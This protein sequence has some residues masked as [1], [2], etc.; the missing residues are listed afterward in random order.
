MVKEEE[1]ISIK[2]IYT[3]AQEKGF[4]VCETYQSIS[5]CKGFMIPNIK[6]YLFLKWQSGKETIS[7]AFTAV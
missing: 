3:H 5:F 4:R 1:P 7:H 6:S 2:K